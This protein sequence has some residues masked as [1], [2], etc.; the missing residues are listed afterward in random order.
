MLWCFASSAC[1]MIVL[2]LLALL[3]HPRSLLAYLSP[4]LM[5]RGC[6]A[7][8]CLCLALLFSALALLVGAPPLL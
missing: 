5:L 7:L 8:V 3:L 4:A 6:L 2:A 1:V